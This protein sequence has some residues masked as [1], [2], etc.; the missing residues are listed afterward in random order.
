[1]RVENMS[2]SERR[3][4]FNKKKPFGKIVMVI[5]G[6][7][8]L[9]LGISIDGGFLWA[10]I[11]AVLS[12]SG[13]YLLVKFH[14]TQSDDAVDEFCNK[15]ADEYC[16]TKKMIVDSQ[17]NDITDAIYSHGYCFENIFCARRAVQGKDHI[18]RSSIFGMSCLIFTKE[19][20]YYY[21]KKIS[22]ITD[23]QFEEQK[24]FCIKDIQM[25]ALEE[26][27]Q[28]IVVAI[29]IPGNEKIYVNCKTK[30]DANELCN[31]IRSKVYKRES[32]V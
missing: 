4:Y 12:I 21:R 16:S 32:S 17:V 18:W 26:M 25:I 31:K 3:K 15:Q 19:V 8:F 30:E 14:Q 5:L 11:G 28:S 22:L 23:E 24:E 29:T 27:N 2:V 20:L 1:M 6:I 7:L 10:I 13:S 9:W